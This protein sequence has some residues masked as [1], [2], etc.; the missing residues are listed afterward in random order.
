MHRAPFRSRGLEACY[1]MKLKVVFRHQNLQAVGEKKQRFRCSRSSEQW[2]MGKPKKILNA[3]PDVWRD[4]F[5]FSG[6]G[7]T[8]LLAEAILGNWNLPHKKSRTRK[9]GLPCWTT[10]LILPGLQAW[11]KVNTDVGHVSLPAFNLWAIAE[12]GRKEG[13]HEMRTNSTGPEGRTFLYANICDT[14]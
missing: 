8:F 2:K 1:F 13:G 14:E 12:R 11:A 3:V 10:F 6:F 4:M 5:H 9:L 7:I